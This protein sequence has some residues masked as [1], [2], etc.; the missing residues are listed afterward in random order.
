MLEGKNL[1]I[2]ILHDYPSKELWNPKIPPVIDY[3]WL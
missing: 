2:L 3:F 1:D